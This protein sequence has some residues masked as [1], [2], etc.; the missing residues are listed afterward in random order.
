[1]GLPSFAQLA[2]QHV[3]DYSRRSVTGKPRPCRLKAGPTLISG[4]RP[5]PHCSNNGYRRF[6]MA[7]E[8]RHQ[9]LGPVWEAAARMKLINNF[10]VWRQGGLALAEAPYLNLSAAAPRRGKSAGHN[11]KAGAP[12][13]PLSSRDLGPMASSTY[14]S[15]FSPAQGR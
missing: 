11:L 5:K 9:P 10:L 2:E 7:N 12:R 14:T 6:E 8:Q 1:M 15:K 4:R 3:A 13:H